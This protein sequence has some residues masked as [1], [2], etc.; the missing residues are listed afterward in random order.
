MADRMW[1]MVMF[2]LPVQSAMQR[3]AANRYRLLLLDL[4]FSMAQLSVYVKYLVN[5]TGLLPILP[6]LK[7]NTPQ[8]GEVRILR[9]TDDQWASMYRY[10]GSEEVNVESKPTQ[11]ALFADEKFDEEP[12]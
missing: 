11:L 4:G 6:L 8:A 9:L 5:A 3:R 7:R 12:F 2:D 1:V 10:Y